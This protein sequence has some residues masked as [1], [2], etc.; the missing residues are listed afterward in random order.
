MEV[1]CQGI[2][3]GYVS[4]L[5]VDS[6]I[7][8]KAIRTNL[9]GDTLA[10][11][12]PRI[13]KGANL[14][15]YIFCRRKK[16]RKLSEFFF[17]RYNQRVEFNGKQ[18][19]KIRINAPS[20]V[21]VSE[22]DE[23]RF[24]ELLSQ[25]VV[26]P[27]LYLDISEEAFNYLLK[28]YGSDWRLMSELEWRGD[29]PEDTDLS[30]FNDRSISSLFKE[31]VLDCSEQLCKEIDLTYE[32][33][34]E[35]YSQTKYLSLNG[36]LALAT[37]DFF[38]LFP[39]LYR[40][41]IHWFHYELRQFGRDFPLR[42]PP[43]QS[44]G[45]TCLPSLDKIVGDFSSVE[46]LRITIM[47]NLDVM[48]LLQ[49]FPN[50]KSLILEDATTEEDLLYLLVQLPPLKEFGYNGTVTQS[51]LEVLKIHQRGLLSLLLDEKNDFIHRELPNTLVTYF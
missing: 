49:M 12:I 40:L 50:L 10:D 43:V 39:T 4:N 48:Q 33:V 42:I 3:A 27:V 26:H 25:I 47:R 37:H 51:I 6:L 41:D 2:S 28:P 17:Y 7:V 1:F 44:L 31:H 16:A 11:W 19:Q 46:V 5:P 18:I 24:A 34:P 36:N 45:L 15:G 22:I 13:D 20:C 14:Y 30:F 8:D 21:N 29:I 35:D 38:S 32:F 23:Q 9:Q